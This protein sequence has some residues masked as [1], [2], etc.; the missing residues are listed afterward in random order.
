MDVAALD[1]KG[2]AAAERMGDKRHLGRGQ[3]CLLIGILNAYKTRLIRIAGESFGGTATG[4]PNSHY[5]QAMLSGVFVVFEA[6]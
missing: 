1:R 2:N 4:Y 3:T 5:Y 6:T